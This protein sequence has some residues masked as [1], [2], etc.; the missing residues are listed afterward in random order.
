MMDTRGLRCDGCGQPASAE[1][2]AR[3]L[4]RLEWAT[5]YRPVHIGSLFLGAFSPR[6]EDEFLYAPGGK[7]T[8]EAGQLL[9]A[10]EIA[11]EGKMAEAIHTEFQRAGCFLTHVLECPLENEQA[12]AVGKEALL[13]DRLPKL[14]SRIRKSLKPRHVILVTEALTPVVQNLLTLDLGCSVMLDNGKPFELSGLK[15]RA[16]FSRFR[17]KLAGAANG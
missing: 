9:R 11:A 8:G 7:F 1:H 15:S 5:R 14:A 16:D 17:Q 3:R 10:L 2:V 6:D 13:K 12:S 4:R